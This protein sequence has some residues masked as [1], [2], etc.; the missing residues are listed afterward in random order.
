[1][2]DRGLFE[3]VSTLEKSRERAIYQKRDAE[4][5][6]EGLREC[7]FRRCEPFIIDNR[8]IASYE[9]EHQSHAGPSTATYSVAP[10]GS[11]DLPPG[12]DA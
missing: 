6:E 9:P 3:F 1:M 8:K 2:K 12:Y 4:N 10:D 11:N 5:Q 7:F